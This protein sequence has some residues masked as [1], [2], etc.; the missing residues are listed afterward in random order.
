MC[1]SLTAL[2]CTINLLSIPE[3]RKIRNNIAAAARLNHPA[4]KII[5][6]TPD[7]IPS[8]FHGGVLCL[9]DGDDDGNDDVDNVP[10]VG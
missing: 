10:Q 6:T 4:R 1:S 2:T 8:P 7:P 5:Q 9:D 3:E